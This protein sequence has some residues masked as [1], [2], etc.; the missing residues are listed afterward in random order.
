MARKR[1]VVVIP[2]EQA[3]FRLDGYGNWHGPQGRFQNRK[4]IEHF[5]LSI[6]RDEQGYHLTQTHRDWKEKVYFP[7][8]DTALFVFGVVK[9]ERVVLVL[10]T[11]KRV[12]LKPRNLFVKDDDLYMK[13]GNEIIKFTDRGLIPLA[14]FLE[15]DE[16]RLF[17]RVRGRRYRIREEAAG[18]RVLG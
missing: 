10:N 9:G 12:G 3:I 5:H 14:D 2:K 17:I 18:D 7:Y 13:L 1:K 8:E 15:G 4:I 16:K 6:R 11:G